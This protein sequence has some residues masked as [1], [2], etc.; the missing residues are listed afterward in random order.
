VDALLRR[1]L[2][3][4]EFSIDPECMLRA[5]IVPASGEVVLDDGSIVR[6]GQAIADLHLWNEH[7]PAV[8]PGGA[9]LTWLVAFDTRLRRSLVELAA[10]LARTRSEVRAIRMETAFGRPG[11]DMD[12]IGRRFGFQIVRGVRAR[13]AGARL[14]RFFANFLFLA[15]SWAYN[16][17]S[18]AG[19]SFRRDH[20]EYWMSR[21]TLD[22]LYGAPPPGG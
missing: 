8:P 7:V 2:R 5:A 21:D 4:F 19:K 20:C 3:I 14:H 1:R 9:D 22:A 15:L 10:Y 18:L 6:Q 12:R 16:P 17:G 11:A 13:T